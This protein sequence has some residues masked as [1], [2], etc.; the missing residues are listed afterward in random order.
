VIQIR[1]WFMAT[2]AIH[3]A[4]AFHPGIRARNRVSWV[5]LCHFGFGISL[6]PKHTEHLGSLLIAQFGQGWFTIIPLYPTGKTQE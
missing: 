4:S 5:A 3:F 6:D 2:P 1:G